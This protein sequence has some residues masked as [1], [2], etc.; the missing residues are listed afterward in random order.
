MHSAVSLL[1]VTSASQNLLRLFAG[2]I[3]ETPLPLQEIENL[4]CHLLLTPRDLL[5][6]RAISLPEPT[7]S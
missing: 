6:Q 5:L 1:L 2:G 7:V 3:F 4:R